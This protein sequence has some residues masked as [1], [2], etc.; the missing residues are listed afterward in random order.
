LSFQ[1]TKT[2][3]QLRVK[4]IPEQ[5]LVKIDKQRPTEDLHHRQRLSHLLL[6]HFH[7]SSSSFICLFSCA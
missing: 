5:T 2:Y 4:G 1:G 6:L 7:T 3:V